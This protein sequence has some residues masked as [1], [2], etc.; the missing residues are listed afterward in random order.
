MT[1]TSSTANG[2]PSGNEGGKGASKYTFN[3]PERSYTKPY[4]VTEKEEAMAL[5]KKLALNND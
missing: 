1:N 3:E 2:T 4:Y 5:A